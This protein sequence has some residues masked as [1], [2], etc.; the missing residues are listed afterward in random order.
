[1]NVTAE[2]LLTSIWAALR[3]IEDNMALPPA[4]LE[5][6]APQVTVHAPDLTDLTQ[7]LMG[8]QPGPTALELAR[9]IAD[10][11]PPSVAKDSAPSIEMYDAIV[12][13][14]ERLDFRLQAPPSQGYIGGSVNLQP[15]QTVGINNWDEMP[16]TS[17]GT[18]EVTNDEG[19]PLPVSGTFWPGT[20]PVSGSVSVSN[21]P[22]TQPVSGTFWQ[23][24]QP[25]SGTVTVANPTTNPETG[26]AKDATLLRRYGD[27]ITKAGLA[28]TIGD[29]T[30]HTPVAG[31]RIR[32]YW[33][34]LSTSQD[35]TAE[36]LAI[37]KLTD[38]DGTTKYR[39]RLGNPGAFVGGRTIEGNA[40]EPLILNLATTDGVDWNVDLEEVT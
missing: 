36:N 18:V 6:P 12:R 38:A 40:D 17:I 19:N 7:T 37:V 22:A 31:K 5:F 23:A 39:W 13:A 8:L 11:L 35:N 33:I 15:N 24:T 20:Q 26:L 28:N 30:L 10:V 4:P 9:A 14:L 29:N 1:V 2:Q 21:L 34:G 16:P 32:L 3:R 27:H 25:V